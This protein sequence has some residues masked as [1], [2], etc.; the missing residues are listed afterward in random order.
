M[1]TNE[2]SRML[3]Q[4]TEQWKNWMV[5]NKANFHT[6]SI[7]SDP[8]A[9]CRLSVSKARMV[10]GKSLAFFSFHPILAIKFF[11]RSFFHGSDKKSLFTQKTNYAKEDGHS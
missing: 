2:I 5:P 8:Q 9:L 4:S 10:F 11:S 7:W 3:T 6:N 1:H